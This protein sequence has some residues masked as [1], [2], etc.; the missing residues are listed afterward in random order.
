M[1]LSEKS[2]FMGR[3][4]NARKCESKPCQI[5]GSEGEELSCVFIVAAAAFQII[6]TSMMDTWSAS[7]LW[8]L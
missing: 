1:V 3:L 5:M 6:Q 8:L 2:L 4:A 7:T